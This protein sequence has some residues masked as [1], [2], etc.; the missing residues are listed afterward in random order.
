MAKSGQPSD[1]QNPKQTK[2]TPSTA[3]QQP[4]LIKEYRTRAER[5]A[6]VQ[7]LLLI[8]MIIVGVV[9]GVLLISA[10]VIDGLI[11][12]NQ[13]AATVNTRN[14]TV[15]EFQ[16]EVRLTRAL[17]N[18][19][20][21]NAVGQYRAIGIPDDQII[22]FLTSQPPYSTWINEM[23]VPDQ[24]GNT[25]LNQMINDEVLRQYAAANNVT[26]TDEQIDEQ[27]RNFF[28][29]D[30]EAALNTP[31]PSPSP[32]VSPTAIVSPT[33]SPTP[34]ETPTPEFTPTTTLTP[35]ASST[36]APTQNATE[37]AESFNTARNDI[38]SELRN[39]TGMSDA[40]IRAYFGVLALHEALRDQTTADIATTAPFVNGRI[41]IVDTE[42]K[43]ND[44]LAALAE[45][46]SFAELARVN[47]SDA[48]ATLGGELDW[49]TLENLTLQYGQ[50]F[51][52]EVEAAA[53]GA[54]VGPI[55]TESGTYAIFQLRGREDRELS[56]AQ[57]DQARDLEFNQHLEDL[58]A[59][60]TVT[61]TSNWVNNVPTDPAFVIQGL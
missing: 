1:A 26:I 19:E 41:I 49:S 46:D 42:D 47:S 54:T 57:L 40:D 44:I 25:V 17:R 59:A 8:S 14:I 43:A 20:L 28:G 23:Q 18:I 34:T 55:A 48:S 31:T 6:R 37:L 11:V 38:F 10:F 33:A 5:E 22:Q 15:G 36:P 7:R 16:R 32:T 9:V 4:K 58:R 13:V 12:P 39:Q 27:I 2:G 3:R 53:T 52:D 35:V 45:G 61:T 60:A 29:Y 50:A 30:P 51:S 56:E 24:L 21:S